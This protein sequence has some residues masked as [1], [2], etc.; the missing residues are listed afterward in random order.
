MMKFWCIIM[1]SLAL[2]V[3]SS[4]II[5]HEKLS[6]QTLRIESCGKN[7]VRVRAVPEGD[8]FRDD[9][10]SAFVDSVMQNDNCT[11]VYMDGSRKNQTFVN[12]NMRVE[13]DGKGGLLSF[14]RVSDGIQLLREQKLRQFSRAP[15]MPKFY[16][17]ELKF[18]AQTSEHIY[19]LGQHKTGKLDNMNVKGLKLEPEN[20]EIL[21][22]VAHSSLGYVFLFNLPSF[23]NVESEKNIR[24]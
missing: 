13:I 21:I 5:V 7:A 16:S 10:V 20:T 4:C 22:P 14:W 19:G 6:K 2:F 24:I 18:E 3:H 12:G 17:L 1:S 8:P 11:E 23:G 9:L 15:R